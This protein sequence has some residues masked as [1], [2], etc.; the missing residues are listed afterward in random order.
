MEPLQKFV[1]VERN[2]FRLDIFLTNIHN[3]SA[4]VEIGT[5]TGNEF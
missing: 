2:L 5:R 4:E 1:S 3:F